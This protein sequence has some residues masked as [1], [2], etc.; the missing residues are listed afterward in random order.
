METS[1]LSPANS[2]TR[3]RS[4]PSIVATPMPIPWPSPEV[5]DEALINIFDDE[6]STVDEAAEYLEMFKSHYIKFFPFVYIPQSITPEQL[7][8]DRPLLWLTIKAI[9]TKSPTKQETLGTKIRE[10]LVKQLLIDGE[11]NIDLLLCLLAFLAWCVFSIP[12]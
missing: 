11:R 5:G 10:T 1:I 3:D 9:C 2:S 8:I 7:Q 4:P 12:S 6:Y